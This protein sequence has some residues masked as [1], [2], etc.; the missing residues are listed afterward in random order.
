MTNTNQKPGRDTFAFV[1]GF[2][3]MLTCCWSCITSSTNNVTVVLVAAVHDI[4]TD[5]AVR[6]WHTQM[7]LFLWQQLLPGRQRQKLYNALAVEKLCSDIQPEGER[8]GFRNERHYQPVEWSLNYPTSLSMT[9][10][11]FCRAQR[12]LPGSGCCP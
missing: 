3:S 2:N 5:S 10:S 6:I 7:A 1:L 12:Q 4:R 8:G 11:R 9:R